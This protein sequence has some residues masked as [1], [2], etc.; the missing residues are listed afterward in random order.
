[1]ERLARQTDS[2]LHNERGDDKNKN[3]L[4]KINYKNNFKKVPRS[5]FPNKF[6]QYITNLN[7][8]KRM[9]IFYS[10]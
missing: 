5:S 2:T 3:N 4:Q 7:V 6:I 8:L 10:E 1:M 9:I